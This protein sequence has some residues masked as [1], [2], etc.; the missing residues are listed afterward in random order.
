MTSIDNNVNI[1]FLQA[2]RVEK[3]GSLYDDRAKDCKSGKSLKEEKVDPPFVINDTL[4]L[5]LKNALLANKIKDTTGVILE[6]MKAQLE[7][8]GINVV[9]LN[10][11]TADSKSLD[12]K[13]NLS[14]QGGS[15]LAQANR[16][17]LRMLK[18]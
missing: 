9:D 16:E 15:G 8:K 13:E 4:D 14:S 6:Q 12:V 18:G 5:A 3:N 10:S 11:L 17:F 7:G 1:T 2:N